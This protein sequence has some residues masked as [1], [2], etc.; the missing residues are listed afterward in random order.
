MQALTEG[1]GEAEA[2]SRMVES[3]LRLPQN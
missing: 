1:F 2:E 3:S